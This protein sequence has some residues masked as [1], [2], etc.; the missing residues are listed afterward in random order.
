MVCG[1]YWVLS[2]V[3]SFCYPQQITKALQ[4]RWR[5]TWLGRGISAQRGGTRT[6]HKRSGGLIPHTVPFNSDTWRAGILGADA[7]PEDTLEHKSL[8]WYYSIKETFMSHFGPSSTRS[9][10]APERSFAG[11]CTQFHSVPVYKHPALGAGCRD[12]RVLL[13]AL[14]HVEH[15]GTGPEPLKTHPSMGRKK[16]GTYQ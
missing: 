6:C 16:T 7:Q 13:A 1:F 2:A 12:L 10:T 5:D 9:R 11:V 3:P 8:T 15:C 14:G 4:G